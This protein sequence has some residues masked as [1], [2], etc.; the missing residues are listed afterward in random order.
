MDF[1]LPFRKLKK[2]ERQ[3]YGD[4]NYTHPGAAQMFLADG[5][6]CRTAHTLLAVDPTLFNG[7]SKNGPRHMVQCNTRFKERASNLVWDIVTEHLPLTG[8]NDNVTA[9][10]LMNTAGGVVLPNQVFSNSFTPE[11]L[12]ANEHY[13]V[14]E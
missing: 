14:E 2:Y 1:P 13:L 4:K 3:S 8:T 5:V 10:C 9:Q 7:G 11:P 6:S 12:H